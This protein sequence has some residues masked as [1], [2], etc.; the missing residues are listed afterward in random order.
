MS[1]KKKTETKSGQTVTVE[2]IN[3]PIHENDAHQA[4][5]ARFETTPE[6]AEALRHFVRIIT[7]P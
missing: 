6:R 7:T 3:Q 4:K 2:V 1:A 5:G